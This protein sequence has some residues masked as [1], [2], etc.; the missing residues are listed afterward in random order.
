MRARPVVLKV[1]GNELDQ[2]G[3]ID[4]L[5]EAVAAMPTSQPCIV[6]HGGGRLINELLERLD[7]APSFHQGQRVTDQ[8]T[9]E[10]VEMVLS[11]RVNK[12][13]V[14][15]LANAGVNALGVSG[16]DLN[17]LQVEPWAAELGYVGRITQVRT[18]VFQGWLE[19]G[20]VPVVS[21][22]SR[23]PGGCYN[24]NA[25]HAAGALAAALS[26]SQLVL[27]TNVPGV[28][29]DGQVVPRLTPAGVGRLID[30]GNINGGMIPKVS[31]ALEALEQ[32]VSEAIITNLAGLSRL[33]GTLFIH[34]DAQESE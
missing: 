11:G 9:L 3:F 32:G 20:I 29:V 17:L 1:G 33:A 22:I 26:A 18:D 28:M 4:R 6:V 19:R 30:S 24:V 7:I 10:V 5:A 2:P 27:L 23:G 8:P 13:L 34:T 14:L 12:S 25:D 16:V 31:A 21:P 15:A